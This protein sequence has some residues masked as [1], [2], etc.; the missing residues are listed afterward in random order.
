MYVTDRALFP[1]QIIVRELLL[2]TQQPLENVD[3]MTPTETLQ[4][5]SVILASLPIIVVYPFL[6]RHFTKGMLLGSIKG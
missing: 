3:N 5:A 2:Q 1:L 4:M 6:Q